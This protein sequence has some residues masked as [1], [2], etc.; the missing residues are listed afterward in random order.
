VLPSIGSPDTIDVAVI[1]PNYLQRQRDV[2]DHERYEGDKLKSKPNRNGIG[3]L[4]SGRVAILLKSAMLRK[5]EMI[6]PAIKPMI[7]ELIRKYGWN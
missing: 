4:I 7:T 6:K 5:T 3:M 1:S 2:N